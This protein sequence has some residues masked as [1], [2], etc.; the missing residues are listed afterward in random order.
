[1]C[2]DF[3]EACIEKA[4]AGANILVFVIPH[5]FIGGLCEKIIKNVAPDCIGV[6]LIKGLD[7]DDKGLVLISDIISGRLG[8]ISI[9]RHGYHIRSADVIPACLGDYRE[10]IPNERHSLQGIQGLAH[11]LSPEF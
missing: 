9:S 7:F 10:R 11:L 6:S 8:E 2:L 5:Q 1:M 3:S 4:V